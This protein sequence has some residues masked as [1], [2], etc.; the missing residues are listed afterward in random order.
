MRRGVA[1]FLALAVVLGGCGGNARPVE[2]VRP[3]LGEPQEFPEGEIEAVVTAV[4][5]LG[6]ACWYDRGGDIP[7]G[8]NCQIGDQAKEDFTQI[9]VGGAETGPIRSVGADRY[10]PA[11]FDPAL[12]NQAAATTFHQLVQIAVPERYRPT[13]AEIHAQVA[14]NHVLDLGDGWW[15]MFHRSSRDRRAFIQFFP[16]ED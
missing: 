4:E 9:S 8:W 5:R 14:A 2:L 13:L 1:A 12:L 15:M 16:P 10:F 6:Y 3:D 11:A 7:S